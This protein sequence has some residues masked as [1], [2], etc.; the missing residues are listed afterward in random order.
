MKMKKIQK[1]EY[2]CEAIALN[3]KKMGRVLLGMIDT[4]CENV[5]RE[6]QLYRVDFELF[7][8]SCEP[9]DRMEE[10]PMGI[11]GNAGA[12]PHQTM[13]WKGIALG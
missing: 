13:H 10:K 11:R 8:L 9:I 4:V 6:R 2:K 7:C 5:A 1:Y 3:M 12:S